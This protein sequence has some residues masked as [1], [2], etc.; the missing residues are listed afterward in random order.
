VSSRWL[1]TEL[2]ARPQ[3]SSPLLKIGNDDSDGD[4]CGFQHL[5]GLARLGAAVKVASKGVVDNLLR[6]RGLRN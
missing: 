6:L 2:K 3:D 4:R 5:V 1:K